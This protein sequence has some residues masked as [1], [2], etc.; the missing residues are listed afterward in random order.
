MNNM[1]IPNKVSIINEDGEIVLDTLV[2][3][4]V[5]GID[6]QDVNLIV[7]HGS[8][9]QIHGVKPEWLSDAP[10]FKSVREHVLQLCGRNVENED[11]ENVPLNQEERIEE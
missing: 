9:Q 4:Y 3:P 11:K 5:N 8:V 6:Y 2:R 10:T 1:N 7:G